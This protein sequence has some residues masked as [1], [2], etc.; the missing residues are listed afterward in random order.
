MSLPFALAG[1]RYVAWLSEGWEGGDPHWLQVFDRQTRTIRK[2]LPG[3][4]PRF[5]NGYVI[6]SRARTLLAA[7]FDPMDG[8]VGAAIPL[9]DG[10]AV[11][12]PGS[13]GGRHYAVARSGTLVYVPA[14]DAYE[15]VVLERNGVDRVVGVGRNH[16]Y[17]LWDDHAF[18]PRRRPG[19]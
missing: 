11:E 15:M 3:T 17:P 16:Q 1:G 14:P 18:L 9:V 8:S 10:V 13:G 4:A 2:L 7:R 19:P 5:A 12:L 6:F